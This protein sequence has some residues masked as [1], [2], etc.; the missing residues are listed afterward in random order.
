MRSADWP[1][2]YISDTPSTGVGTDDE[3]D[4]EDVEEED[5]DDEDED[6]EEDET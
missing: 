6:E 2:A 5:E 1:N 3:L 4:D